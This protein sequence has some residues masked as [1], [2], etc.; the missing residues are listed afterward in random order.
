M[1]NESIAWHLETHATTGSVIVA[2]VPKCGH[3]TM[4]RG[5]GKEF[6]HKFEYRVEAAVLDRVVGSACSPAT[7][8]DE[9]PNYASPQRPTASLVR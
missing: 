9:G 1:I 2:T 6:T 3:V 5:G 4:W 7:N 8:V